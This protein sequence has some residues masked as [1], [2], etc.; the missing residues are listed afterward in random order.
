MIMKLS[1]NN[2]NRIREAIRQT[3]KQH[4]VFSYFPSDKQTHE[5]LLKIN[6]EEMFKNETVYDSKA[7][8]PSQICPDIYIKKLCVGEVKYRRRCNL[9]ASDWNQPMKYVKRFQVPGF[10]VLFD[11]DEKEEPLIFKPAS[12]LIPERG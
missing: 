5:E 9:N 3:Q 8:G 1:D 7:F 2:K 10:L 12:H 4:N 6:L 11:H